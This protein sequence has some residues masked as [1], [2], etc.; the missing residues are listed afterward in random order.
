MTRSFLVV[1]ALALGLL[2]NG[3]F[4]GRPLYDL[5]MED[6]QQRIECGAVSPTSLTSC[7]D[8]CF[9]T[10]NIIEETVAMACYD[11]K[12]DLTTCTLELSCVDY[13]SLEHGGS[14]TSA[15]SLP[16]EAE[17][18]YKLAVCAESSI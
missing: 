1:S 8:E 18:L 6:C 7:A 4:D 15:G 11:A 16:C 10:E 2:A 12:V 3:C 9:T 5:C 17:K 14:T 13:Q